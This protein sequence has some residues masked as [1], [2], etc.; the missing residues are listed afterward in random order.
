MTPVPVPVPAPG[1]LMTPTPGPGV[2][3]PPQRPAERPTKDY[4]YDVTDS[5]AGTGIDL[6]AEEQ[7]MNDLRAST[8]PGQQTSLPSL[9]RINH[10]ISLL[11]S[12]R[13][14]L[15][16]SLRCDLH[17]S[18]HRRLVILFCWSPCCIDVRIRS[19]ENITWR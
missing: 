8:V 4:E 2:M 14:G 17:F 1:Q 11:H 13:R 19:H 12:K 15:G 3:G 18:G 5:L 6:R 16:Q 7:Y 10:R 9:F